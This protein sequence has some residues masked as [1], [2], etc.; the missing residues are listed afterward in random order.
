M[1]PRI[2]TVLIAFLFSTAILRAQQN[3]EDV[4]KKAEVGDAKAQNE[5][6]VMYR[7]GDGVA[8]D[9]AESVKW[10]RKAAFQKNPDALYNLGIAY[11]NGDGVPS[12]ELRAYAFLAI[13]KEA[14]SAE[15][16]VALDQFAQSWPDSKLNVGKSVEAEIFSRGIDVP[17]NDERAYKLY[18]QVAEAGDPFAQY[19]ICLLLDGGRG[20]KKDP[21]E[22]FEWC[23]KAAKQSQWDAMLFVADRYEHGIGTSIDFQNAEHW[24]RFVAYDRLDAAMRIAHLYKNGSLKSSDPMLADAYLAHAATGDKSAKLELD[25]DLAQ[26]DKKK[27]KKFDEFAKKLSDELYQMKHTKP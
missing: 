15:A 20:V 17:E 23:L 25:S 24:Y 21:I 1:R 10:Y 13:A 2:H 27:R 11:F 6:G 4:K 18:R 22:A 12:N 14:G 9:K 19:T 26:L 3:F 7:Q 5:L 16:G 8:R